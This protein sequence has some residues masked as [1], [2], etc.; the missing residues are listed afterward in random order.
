LVGPA[1][2][3]S[4]AKGLPRE[5]RRNEKEEGRRKKVEGRGRRK[6]EEVRREGGER[7]GSAPGSLLP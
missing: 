1:A 6:K 4:S 7:D 3:V 2:Y 5:E